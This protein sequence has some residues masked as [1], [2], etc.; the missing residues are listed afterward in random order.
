MITLSAAEGQIL[1]ERMKN[2]HNV[3]IRNATAECPTVAGMEMVLGGIVAPVTRSLYGAQIN[4]GLHYENGSTCERGKFVKQ[5]MTNLLDPIDFAGSIDHLD[6]THVFGGILKNEHFGNFITESLG[7]LWIAKILGEN[8]KSFVFYPRN[9]SAPI[10]AYMTEFIKLIDPEIEIRIV[11]SVTRVEALVVPDALVQPKIGYVFGHPLVR[12]VMRPLGALRGEGHR[13]LYVS[14]SKMAKEAGIICECQI[15]LNLSAEGYLVIHPEKL[16]IEDQLRAYND[17]TELVFAEGSAL[18]LYALIAR[19]DQKVFIIRRRSMN[20]VFDWQIASFGGQVI[21]SPPLVKSLWVP[22]SD[23]RNRPHA[24]AVL[25]FT[26]LRNLL[27]TEGFIFGPSWPEPSA[28]EIACDI[29]AR[30]EVFGER[31]LEQAL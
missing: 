25:D 18:H 15:E 26:A 3:R 24:Q 7:R 30:Q 6:G 16:S 23:D 1:P 21:Y 27:L 29:E 28:A 22:E 11:R 8:L 14:K 31:L 17:A 19:P 9:N 10:S 2:D 5:G 13:R 20:M 12:N 4:G